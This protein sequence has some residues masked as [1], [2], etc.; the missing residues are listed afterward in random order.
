MNNNISFNVEKFEKLY[1]EE[2]N[3]NKL[4]ADYMPSNCF[5]F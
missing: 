2:R 1:Q 4:L 3:Y 5:D